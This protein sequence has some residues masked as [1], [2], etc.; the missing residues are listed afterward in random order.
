MLDNGQMEALPTIEDAEELRDLPYSPKRRRY[1]NERMTAG[2]ST[3]RA[4]AARPVFK[5]PTTPASRF[6]M[7]QS[8]HPHIANISQEGSQV[9]RPAFLRSSIAPPEQ[10]EPLPEAFSPHRRGEKF[11]PGGMAAT[12]QQWV[13]ETGQSATQSKRGKGYLQGEDYVKRCRVLSVSGKDALMVRGR[14]SGGTEVKLLLMANSKQ[15]HVAVGDDICIRA[16]I[17]SVQLEGCSWTVC[18]DWKIVQ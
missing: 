17:W 7:A 12:L 10:H 8:D 3:M 14:E 5:Q 6:P 1:S 9:R 18:V 11:V 13:I 2:A 4:S 15:A 16:P